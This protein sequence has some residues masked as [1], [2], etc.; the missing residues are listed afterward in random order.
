MEAWLT[1]CTET[2]DPDCLVSSFDTAALLSDRRTAPSTS[3]PVMR[4]RCLPS[5]KNKAGSDQT[6]LRASAEIESPAPAREQTNWLDSVVQDELTNI[7]FQV[8]D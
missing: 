6:A 2:Y 3:R 4:P 5:I 1:F 7:V 8:F